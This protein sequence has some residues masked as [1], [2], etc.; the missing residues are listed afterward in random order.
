MHVFHG[1]KLYIQYILHIFWVNISCIQNILKNSRAAQP[2]GKIT[3]YIDP[4]DV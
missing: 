4:C 1:G 2:R 3:L